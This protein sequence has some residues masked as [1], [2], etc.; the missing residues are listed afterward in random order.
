MLNLLTMEERYVAAPHI[1]YWSPLRVSLLYEI[2][3]TGYA[4]K[5]KVVSDVFQGEPEPY[6]ECLQKTY[7]SYTS[8]H[9]GN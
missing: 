1:R 9:V 5:H 2:G 6:L 7:Q 8:Q 3:E 4:L